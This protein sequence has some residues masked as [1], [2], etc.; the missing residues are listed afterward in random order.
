MLPRYPLPS[1]H[2]PSVVDRHRFDADQDPNFHLDADPDPDLD[3]HQH[4][5]DPH[6]D[7]IP[8]YEHVENQYCGSASF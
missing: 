3:R 7:P 5:A 4:D 1:Q 2:G 6:A 8:R